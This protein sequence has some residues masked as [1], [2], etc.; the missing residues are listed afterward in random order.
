MET[1]KSWIAWSR[2]NVRLT[3][4]APLTQSARQLGAPWAEE[5]WLF[6]YDAGLGWLPRDAF[7]EAQAPDPTD[8]AARFSAVNFYLSLSAEDDDLDPRLHY[9]DVARV[10]QK[11]RDDLRFIAL[12]F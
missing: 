3:A 4:D 11:V 2:E 12:I 6:D 7:A 1:V 9:S 8:F 10:R 5:A